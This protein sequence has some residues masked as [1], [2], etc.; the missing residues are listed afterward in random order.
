[1]GRF[2]K[3]EELNGLLLLMAT[4]AGAWMTGACVPVDGGQTK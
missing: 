3:P 2:G 4:E 1:M